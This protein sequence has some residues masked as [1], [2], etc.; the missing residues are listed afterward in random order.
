MEGSTTP[1]VVEQG[2]EHDGWTVQVAGRAWPVEVLDER[3][4]QLRE[5]A[6]RSDG[7][8]GGGGLVKAPMPGLV[9][10][11]EVEEGQSVGRGT[12]LVVL[13]AMKMENEI[14]AVGVGVVRRILVAAGTAVE[15]GT[16]LVEIGPSS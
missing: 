4:M 10:R 8:A 6:R 7:A 3:A 1:M 15:K 12:G 2:G 14:R 13:E 16:P 9:L 5:M 11:W